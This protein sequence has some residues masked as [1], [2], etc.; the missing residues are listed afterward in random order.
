MDTT[1]MVIGVDPVNLTDS[2]GLDDGM[3]HFYEHRD[4][5]IQ[6]V[7]NAG[8]AVLYLAVVDGS[9]PDPVRGSP[10][11]EIHLNERLRVRQVGADT[12]NIW[13]WSGIEGGRVVVSDANIIDFS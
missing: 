2:L 13:M 11:E 9:N 4:Y 12:G 10:A 7:A 5:S 8:G 1:G 6:N 3:T